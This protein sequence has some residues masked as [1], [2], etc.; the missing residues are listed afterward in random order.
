[1]WYEEKR[2]KDNSKVQKSE[3]WGHKIFW[4]L[5]LET[6]EDKVS[7][8]KKVRGVDFKHVCFELMVK[9]QLGLFKKATEGKEWIKIKQSG[10]K[11]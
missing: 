11:I 7:L 9:S 3:R 8:G 6:S 5:E 4:L 2:S 1:M 10:E